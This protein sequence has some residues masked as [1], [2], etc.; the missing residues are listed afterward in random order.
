MSPLIIVSYYKKRYF[1]CYSIVSGALSPYLVRLDF[2]CYDSSEKA[3]LD[4]KPN[5]PFKLSVK[6]ENI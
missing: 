2:L 1:L 4:R 5:F 6:F 3:Y